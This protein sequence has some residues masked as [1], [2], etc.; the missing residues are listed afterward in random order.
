MTNKQTKEKTNKKLNRILTILGISLGLFFIILLIV[1]SSNNSN[2]STHEASSNQ[3]AEN[4]KL[5]PFNAE[6]TVMNEMMV[7]IINRNDYNWTNV[8]IVAND[9]YTCIEGTTFESG[10]QWRLQTYQCK[11]SQGRGNIGILTP[12]EKIEIIADQG[13]QTFVVG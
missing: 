6:A 13:S 4:I 2:T 5:S 3:P 10:E 11:D 7:N 8:K 12:L 1:I 9:Y